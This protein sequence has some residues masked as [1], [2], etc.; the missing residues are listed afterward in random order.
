VKLRNQ[1]ARKLGFMNF[2]AMQ[3]ALGEQD[4]KKIKRLWDQLDQLTKSDYAQ[5]KGEVDAFLAKRLGL[6]PEALRPWHYQDRFFQEAPKIY[7]VDLDS[8]YARKDLVKMAAGFYSGIGLPIDD[9]LARSDLFEKP[10]KYQ[11]AFCTDIDRSGDVCILCSLKPNAYWMNTILHEAGHG[12]YAKFNDRALPWLLRDSAHAFTI[13]AIANLFGRF[14]TNPAWVEAVAAIS[15]AERAR[16]EAPSAKAL[17]LEQ[18]VFSRWSQVMFRFEKALYE[19]PDQ[20][21]DKLWWDLVEHYQLL[22]RPEGRSAPD[23][24]AKIHVALYPAF[25]HN[26]LLGQLLASQLLHHATIKVLHAKDIQA[27]SF[28]GRKE[29]GKYFLEKVFKPGARYP[30]NEMIHLAT[31][32]KLTAKYYAEQF[33]SK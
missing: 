12:V 1:A 19:N 2:Q 3:L 32:E 24:A 16:I 8:T 11:H 14:A 17:R 30:W 5:V 28:V 22:K 25:C 18:L 23:W 29:V 4:P 13:E 9:I 7:P 26:Y 20:D 6:A 10:G 15:P 27:Q 31:G 21:L 33:L